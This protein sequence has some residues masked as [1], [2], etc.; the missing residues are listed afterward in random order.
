MAEHIVAPGDCILSLAA[1][2]GFAWRTLWDLPENAA[3]KESR[4]NPA[5]LKPGDRVEVP[6]RRDG[7]EK[8]ASDARH[9]FEVL[10]QPISL[11]IRLLRGGA[12]VASQPYRLEVDGRTLTGSTDGDGF[13]RVSVPAAAVEARLVLAELGDELALEI[14]SLEPASEVA[15]VQARLHNLG[16]EIDAVSGELDPKT[17]EKVAIFQETYDLEVTGEPDEPTAKKLQSVHGC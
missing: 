9:T 15:G 1:A 11:V 5:I 4:G 7:D 2:S 17:K 6:A 8:A 13:V 14:G 10:A 16:F 3:L 12:A